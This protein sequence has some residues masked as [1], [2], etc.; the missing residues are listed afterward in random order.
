MVLHDSHQGGDMWGLGGN[1]NSHSQNPSPDS[2][3]RLLRRGGGGTVGAVEIFW[4]LVS[5]YEV[6][7]SSYPMTST[8]FWQFWKHQ[9]PYIVVCCFKYLEWYLFA[10]LSINNILFS[11]WVTLL[12]K[13]YGG[14]R[15]TL[16]KW[17]KF[18]KI[19]K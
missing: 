19:G 4:T 7:F 8:S 17:V 15:K 3:L 14:R 5:S 9:M 18:T 12:I 16:G 2:A 11:F 6:V 10:T 13:P 1:F